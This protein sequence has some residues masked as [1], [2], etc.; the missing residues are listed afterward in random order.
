MMYPLSALTAHTPSTLNSRLQAWPV[1]LMG[2]CT[3]VPALAPGM[4]RHAHAR[5]AADASEV[6]KR[7]QR[8]GG[9]PV[10]P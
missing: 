3:A 5:W 2:A 7:G 9:F 6:A 8:C 10:L 4:D 1:G